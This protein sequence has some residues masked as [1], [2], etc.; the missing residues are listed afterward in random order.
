MGEIFRGNAALTWQDSDDISTERVLLLREPLRE[1]RPAHTQAAYRA[2]SLDQTAIQV[3]TVGVG[4]DELIGRIRFSDQPQTLLD[5]IKAGTKLRT[6]NYFPDLDDT[7]RTVA[8]YLVSPVSPMQLTL[9]SE[10][11]SKF[12]E[13]EVEI[14][15]RRT[16]NA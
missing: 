15:F 12:L 3:F 9:D 6:I 14:R 10:T 4:V 2:V 5:L 7:N 11:G 8:C 13:Q 16:T 1:W